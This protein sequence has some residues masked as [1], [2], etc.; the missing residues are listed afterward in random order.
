MHWCEWLLIITSVLGY[1]SGEYLCDELI[2]YS[3][4]YIFKR[5]SWKKKADTFYCCSA[6]A[7]KRRWHQSV[8]PQEQK[9]KSLT[10]CS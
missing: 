8:C 9:R 3:Y 1:C 4:L 10:W 5:H 6:Q 2:L 7:T